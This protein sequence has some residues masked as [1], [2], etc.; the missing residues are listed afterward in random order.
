[1]PSMD[2]LATGRRHPLLGDRTGRRR[3]R[4]TRL[5]AGDAI[6][7]V[8]QAL[9]FGD[10]PDPA[11]ADLGAGPDVPLADPEIE[12]DLAEARAAGTLMDDP[13]DAWGNA[14][15]PGFGIGRP[16][17]APSLDPA[18][19]PLPL[20]TPEE[21]ARVKRTFDIE[22]EALVLA[23]SSEVPLL[24]AYGTP[25]AVEERHRETYLL[26]LLGASLAIVSAMIFAIM[27]AGGF[28]T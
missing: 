22:P 2:E 28:G 14:A 24:I 23:A 6:T 18:A 3:Y 26:G 15:I 25:G 20:A 1:M 17:S 5:E 19:N 12:A 9:P 10:L 13:D 4:E 7:I 8:G 27:L 16:V 11:G 21:A